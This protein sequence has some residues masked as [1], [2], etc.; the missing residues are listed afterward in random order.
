MRSL[1]DSSTG[2]ERDGVDDLRIAGAAAEVPGDRFADGVLV[3]AT[4]CIEVR[5]C[6]HEHPR[7]ADAALG[8]TRDKERALQ[9]VEVIAAAADPMALSRGIA[10][11][12]EAVCE[13]VN[14]LSTPINE[15]NKKEIMD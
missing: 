5:A 3:G 11:A 2:D 1:G 14:K 12:T 7:R 9:L 10:K 13:A 4:T 6:C 8:A 15:K